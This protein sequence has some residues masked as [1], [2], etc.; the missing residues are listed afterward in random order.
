MTTYFFYHYA[1]LNGCHYIASLNMQ[2]TSGLSILMHGVISLPD[3][4]SCDK[5]FYESFLHVFDF[6]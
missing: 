3:A 1:T 5:W 2:T 4:T 6:L